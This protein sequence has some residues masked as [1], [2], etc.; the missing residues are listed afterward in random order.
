MRPLHDLRPVFIL[1]VPTLREIEEAGG[2]ATT[3]PTVAGAPAWMFDST[4]PLRLLDR[5]GDLLDLPTITEPA[6]AAAILVRC[7]AGTTYVPGN[8]P[9][10]HRDLPRRRGWLVGTTLESPAR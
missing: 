4:A 1:R 3:P 2:P 6:L 10:H 7:S 9:L 5:G 8:P